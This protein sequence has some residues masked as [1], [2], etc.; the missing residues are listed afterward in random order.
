MKKQLF[1]LVA[2]L[3]SQVMAVDFN[4][5]IS[6]G[7]CLSIP[8]CNQG[9]LSKG[10]WSSTDSG[11]RNSNIKKIKCEKRNGR[12][13]LGCMGLNIRCD[14]NAGCLIG[15]GD[16]LGCF[17]VYD[18][19]CRDMDLDL[20]DKLKNFPYFEVWEKK[21]SYFETNLPKEIWNLIQLAAQFE[22]DCFE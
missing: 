18:Q 14:K 21:T 15:C 16:G 20:Q 2:I 7:D 22:I 6:L 1:A 13:N 8:Q 5:E 19:V 4:K 10:G 9:V 11:I 3:T 17:T 12:A